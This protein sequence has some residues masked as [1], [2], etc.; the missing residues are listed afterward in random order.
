M[1]STNKTPQNIKYVSPTTLFSPQ[2]TPI[3]PLT[4]KTAADSI[5]QH[6]QYSESS[7]SKSLSIGPKNISDQYS[8]ELFPTQ[9]PS[10]RDYTPTISD[11]STSS[12]KS[13]SF[14]KY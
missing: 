11:D 1:P 6:S 13:S 4:T 5:Y 3:P 14:G 10:F 2:T 8:S 9:S 12:S 7:S